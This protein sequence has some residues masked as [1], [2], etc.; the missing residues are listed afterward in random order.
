M[1]GNPVHRNTTQDD[2]AKREHP[3][4][5]WFRVRDSIVRALNQVAILSGINYYGW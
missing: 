2:K 3:Y 1:A 5:D 4:P